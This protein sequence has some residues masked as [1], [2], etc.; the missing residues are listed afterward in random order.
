M[1]QSNFVYSLKAYPSGGIT[2]MGDMVR[3]GSNDPNSKD[4]MIIAYDT[5]GN[6]I[7]TMIIIG[8]LLI[9]PLRFMTVEN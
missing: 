1:N 7:G 5:S 4:G 2:V 9:I 3:I 8:M 6:N